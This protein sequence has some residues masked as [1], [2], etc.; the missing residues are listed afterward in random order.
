M[1]AGA[2]IPP[3]LLADDRARVTPAQYTK[4]IQTLWE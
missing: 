3:S 4:L 2:G 1:L